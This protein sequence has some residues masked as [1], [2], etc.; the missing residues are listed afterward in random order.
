MLNDKS[1]WMT[2]QSLL[3]QQASKLYAVDPVFHLGILVKNIYS[4]R[5]NPR[6]EA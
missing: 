4:H 6:H 3:S 2:S 1:L 5:N